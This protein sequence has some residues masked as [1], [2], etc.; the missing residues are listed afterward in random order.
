MVSAALDSIPFRT[1]KEF[2]RWYESDDATAQSLPLRLELEGRPYLRRARRNKPLSIAAP[3]Y[4]F[5]IDVTVVQPPE[6]RTGRDRF[7]LMV[8][9]NS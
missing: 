6:P 8:E 9:V 7:L 2:D 4:S 3:P 5:Q 1:N